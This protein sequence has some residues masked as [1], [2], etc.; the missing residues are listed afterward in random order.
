[1]NYQAS[2]YWQ[3]GSW[4]RFVIPKPFCRIDF[5]IQSLLLEGMG[6]DEAKAYLKEKML[7]YTIV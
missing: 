1:M 5:Y 7:E 4:D 2:S 3:L 6:H